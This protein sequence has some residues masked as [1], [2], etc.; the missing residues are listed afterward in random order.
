MKHET[1]AAR[2][3]SPPKIN[4]PDAGKTTHKNT[5]KHIPERNK[6]PRE[7]ANTV[8]IAMR[9]EPEPKF[10]SAAELPAI[11]HDNPAVASLGTD[12]LLSVLT[13]QGDDRSFQKNKRPNQ[14]A[15]DES[16]LVTKSKK[17]RD[18]F[19]RN[20]KSREKGNDNGS[21]IGLVA[22][23]AGMLCMVG[24]FLT[25]IFPVIAN[26]VPP[27]ILLLCACIAIIFGAFGLIK[28][29]DKYALA[30]LL[31][32]AVLLLLYVVTSLLL[33]LSFFTL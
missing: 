16:N 10:S 31:S 6:D 20:P 28:S 9:H 2:I 24:I 29:N 1:Y 15:Y 12:Y 4:N 19:E 3:K 26:S 32:G 11:T 17:N 27:L 18:S 5:Q 23:I 30:G 8:P 33:A 21:W 7:T 22:L 13:D 25:I 14:N